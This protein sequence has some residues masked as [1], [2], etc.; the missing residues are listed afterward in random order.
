MESVM[1]PTGFGAFIQKIY[2]E[3]E[4]ADLQKA[5]AVLGFQP[6]EINEEEG[7][8]VYLFERQSQKHGKDEDIVYFLMFEFPEDIKWKVD[9]DRT[10]Y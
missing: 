2:V 6:I 9:W 5:T 10:D 7:K 4:T 3:I 8:A 1:K